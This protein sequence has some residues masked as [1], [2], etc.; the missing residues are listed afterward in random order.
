MKPQFAR[1][2][3]IA[4]AQSLRARAPLGCGPLAR[5]LCCSL[6]TYRP[7]YARRSRLASGPG[8]LQQNAKLFLR[9]P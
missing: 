4:I 5:W 8:G 6:L 1:N 2:C 7:G 9:E 3:D